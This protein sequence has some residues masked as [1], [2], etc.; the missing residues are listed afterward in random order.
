MGTQSNLTEK[1]SYWLNIKPEAEN[2]NPI[3]INW[4][5]VD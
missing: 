5:N 4:D 2:K 1:Y 3:C